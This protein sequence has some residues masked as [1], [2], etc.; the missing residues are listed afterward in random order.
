MCV[1]V[2]VCIYTC[3]ETLLDTGFKLCS[4][5]LHFWHCALLL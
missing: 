1:C 3:T 4:R 2:C 5:M